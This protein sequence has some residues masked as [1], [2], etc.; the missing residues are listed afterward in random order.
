MEYSNTKEMMTTMT[1]KQFYTA[2]TLEILALEAEVILAGSTTDIPVYDGE[3]DGSDAI[4]SNKK[5]NPW[6]HSWE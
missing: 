1:K 6:E 2:P 5:D 3:D 4:M